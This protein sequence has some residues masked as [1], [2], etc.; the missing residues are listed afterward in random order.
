MAPVVAVVFTMAIGVVVA[1][2]LV[3]FFAERYEIVSG[4]A[5]MR[6]DVI[7]RGPGTS[8]AAVENGWRA[9][10]PVCQIAAQSRLAFPEPTHAIPKAVIP[11]GKTGGMIAQLIAIRPRIPRFRN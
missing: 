3:V 1:I 8:V 6:R 2:R 5:I 10:Q 7:D 4:E 11:F 9:D